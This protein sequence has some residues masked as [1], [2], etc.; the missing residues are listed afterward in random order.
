MSEIRQATSFPDVS[1]EDWKA[2]AEK[3]LRGAAFE[4]LISE[5]EDGL[6]RGPLFDQS[7]RSDTHAAL[8][9]SDEPLLDGR[10][11]HMCAPVED[12][13]IDFA[14]TQLLEDLKGG[15]SAVRIGNMPITR[16]ADLRRLLE[17][18]YIELVPIIFAP[19][20]PGAAHALE[21]DD[22]HKT[23][24]TLGMNPLSDKSDTPEN[25]RAFTIN[26]AAIHEAGG[27]DGLEL[28]VFTA[29]VA[30]SFRRHGQEVEGD[31]SALFAVGPDTHLNIVKVRAARKLYAGVASAFGIETPTLPIHTIT[32]LRMMQSQDA[33]TNMLRTSSAGFGAVVGGADYL[34]LRPFTET[35]ADRRLGN[36]TP[37]GHRIA[38]NQQLLM[39]EESHLGQVGD[40]AYGS[41]FHEALTEEMAQVAWTQF[42]AIEAAGGLPAFEASGVLQAAIEADKAKRQERDDPILGVTL[43]PS[44]D[45]PA[46][47]VR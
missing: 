1:R 20:S 15:A 18:V 32:S 27:S 16:R 37:F 34:T 41:Y 8:S 14:N 36:A 2:L 19:D 17:G 9:R 24:V 39:M 35:P 31:L 29:T 28:A 45:V 5:T 4:T 47:E 46:A 12:S 33:W 10:P 21:L 30:E 44:D 22:L 25:W 6:K 7:D 23:S 11:W 40:A 13:D 38:R 43:H 3:G 42:Q 26:A